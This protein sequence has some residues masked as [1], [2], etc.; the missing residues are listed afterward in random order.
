MKYYKKGLIAVTTA[1]L[2]AAL[3]IAFAAITASINNNQT[4]KETKITFNQNPRLKADF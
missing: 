1:I 3:I 4:Q 2:G